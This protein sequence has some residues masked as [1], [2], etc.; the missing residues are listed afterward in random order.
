[1]QLEKHNLKFHWVK[2]PKAFHKGLTAVLMFSL[3]SPSPVWADSDSQT[4][5]IAANS[6][7]SGLMGAIENLNQ[8]MRTAAVNPMDDWRREEVRKAMSAIPSAYTTLA[9][10]FSA[11]V[12]GNSSLPV[13]QAMA[14]AAVDQEAPHSFEKFLKESPKALTP[15]QEVDFSLAHPV[16]AQENNVSMKAVLSNPLKAAEA[17]SDRADLANLSRPRSEALPERLSSFSKEPVSERPSETAASESAVAQLGSDLATVEANLKT[18]TPA[19]SENEAAAATSAESFAKD[20]AKEESVEKNS[21][22]RKAASKRKV[23]SRVRKP[24]S[25]LLAPMFYLADWTV[26]NH[27]ALAETPIAPGAP[28]QGPQSAANPSGEGGGGAGELLFGV[29]AIMGAVAPMVVA[30]QQAN[31]QKQQAQIEA[32]AQIQQTQIQTQ[33]SK[34]LAQLSAQT[35]MAQADASRQVAQMNNDAQTQ[36]LQLNLAAAQAQRDEERQAKV[37]QQNYQRQLE[38]QR[39]AIADRQANESIRLAQENLEAQKLRMALGLSDQTNQT[40][41]RTLQ[42]MTANSQ[43]VSPLVAAL[44]LQSTDNTQSDSLAAA[45]SASARRLLAAVDSSVDDLEK[46]VGANQN[47]SSLFSAKNVQ[48]SRARA[49]TT[50]RGLYRSGLSPVAGGSFAAE[51]NLTSLTSMS[52]LSQFASEV[53]AQPISDNSFA[54]DRNSRIQSLGTTAHGFSG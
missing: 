4:R 7:V 15:S 52:D 22:S 12:L 29:A 20:E 24:T 18:R 45:G 33:T 34:D 49:L 2:N 6:S 30:S 44:G 47:Q 10:T 53:P 3:I 36:R 17:A 21:K 11:S 8:A 40:G 42:S 39:L 48:N 26:S 46:S 5:A 28:G 43:S 16:S 38:A 13:V 35:A 41:G 14:A 32:N 19:S 51:K 54:Q 31:A 27:E 50:S 1:M 9:G 25:W 23:S 37:E